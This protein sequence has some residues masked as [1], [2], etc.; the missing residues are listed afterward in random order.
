LVSLRAPP[1]LPVLPGTEAAGSLKG[2]APTAA[3][4]LLW[5]RESKTPVAAEVPVTG[6]SGTVLFSQLAVQGRVDRSQPGY[7]PVAERILLNALQA[8][9]SGHSGHE[10]R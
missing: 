1:C 2:P 8:P 3:E 9:G 10:A 4:K 7:D 5:V 6:G